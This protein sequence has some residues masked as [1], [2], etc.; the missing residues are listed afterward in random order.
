MKRIQFSKLIV[1]METALVAWTTWRTLGFVR[2]AIELN[3]TGSM[4]YLT[5]LISAVWAAYGTSVSFY[6]NKSKAK[7]VTRMGA[8]TAEHSEI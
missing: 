4:P 5:T 6:Y 3:F 2:M 1:L 7:N 8:G